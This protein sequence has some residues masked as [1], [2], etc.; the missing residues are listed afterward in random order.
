M[1][2]VN[3]LPKMRELNP[4]ADVHTILKSVFQAP[5]GAIVRIIPTCQD[6]KD[7][8]DQSSSGPLRLAIESINT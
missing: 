3:R 1:S 5:G 6:V 8:C 7:V 2:I 4:E